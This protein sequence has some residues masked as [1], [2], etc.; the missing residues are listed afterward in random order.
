MENLGPDQI[1]DAL[2]MSKCIS[3]MEEMYRYES[4]NIYR[5]PIRT[6]IRIDSDSIILTMPSYSTRLKRF[7]VKII[8]EFKNNPERYSLPIQ[9]GL[10]VLIDATNSSVLATLD[11]PMITAIRTGAVSGLA[12][13]LLAKE[14]SK[15]VAVIGS[16]QQARTQLEAVCAVRQ[17]S[18]VAVYSR[19][20]A[21]ADKFAVEMSKALRTSVGTKTER[22]EALS[23]ADIVILATNSPMPVISWSEISNGCHINS[24]GA[25]PERIET[26]LETIFHSRVFVDNKV[27]VAQEA[28]D[29]LNALRS[30]RIS[31]DHIRGDLSDLVL[32]RAKGRTSENEVTFFKSVGFALQDVY[33]SS[34]AYNRIMHA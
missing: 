23:G 30:G 34:Y 25:L 10:I 7:A 9:G 22:R 17:I 29:V 24:I 1:H 15:K 18:E 33:A 11:A 26:D 27:A 28:G 8:T 31:E 13:R 5:Q 20:R 2:P 14:S 4:E 3:V 32:G 12:T 16:G 6:P 21:N 19:N